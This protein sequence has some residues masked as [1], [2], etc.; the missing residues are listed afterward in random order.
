VLEGVGVTPLQE[1]VYLALVDTPWATPASI[2]QAVGV[3]ASELRDC[4][5]TMESLGLVSRTTDDPP[6]LVP[7]PPDVAV[8]ALVARQQEGVERARSGAAALMGRYLVDPRTVG[9]DGLVEIMQGRDAVRQRFHQLQV[10]ATEELLVLDK[11]PYVTPHHDSDTQRSLLDR[12][13]CARTIY[14][15]QALDRPEI[16]AHIRELGGRGERARL[17]PTL[18]LKLAIADRRVALVPLTSD[19]PPME[20][21]ALVHPCGLL[22]AL[23]ELFEVLWDRAAPLRLHAPSG[24]GDGDV[25]A[26]DQELLALMVAGM[27][28]EDIATH[29]EVTVRTIGRR[30]AHLMGTVG[31]RTRF[32]LGWHLGRRDGD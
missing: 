23:I 12:G 25:S 24:D 26:R 27:K 22:D 20:A 17:V 16:V 30:V 9:C 10:G 1:R 2:E 13:V 31:A 18:P 7:A 6:R 4:L 5:A 14:E 15:Q 3:S 28:D 32:Q 29:L 19:Q 11:P 21:S 8:E